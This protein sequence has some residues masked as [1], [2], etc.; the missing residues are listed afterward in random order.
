MR[1]Y[2]Q[3]HFYKRVLIIFKYRSKWKTKDLV[4]S[5]FY[6]TECSFSSI[7]I[8]AFN[9]FQKV[10]YIFLA[11]IL[12]ISCIPPGNEIPDDPR[13]FDPPEANLLEIGSSLPYFLD[14]LHA[15][16]EIN[17]TEILEDKGP[18]TV[19]MPNQEAFVKFRMEYNIR[20]TQEIP[21]DKLKSILLYH[22]IHGR[23]NFVSVPGGYHP[24]LSFEKTTG[25]PIDL[26]IETDDL[27]KINGVIVWR[28]EDLKAANGVIHS[29]PSVL[30]VPTIETHLFLNN[31]FS[32]IYEILCRS[33]LD[34]NYSQLLSEDG[35]Y[36][37]LAPT[38]EAIQSFID[39]NNEWQ[40]IYDI[41][42]STVSNLIKYHL[43]PEEN[44][45]LKNIT[46]KT[47]ITSSQGIN[48]TILAEFPKWSFSVED[49]KKTRVVKNDIQGSNGVIHQIDRALLPTD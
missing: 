11:L 7:M 26:F 3:G 43:I 25:N 31:E 10:Q 24:T 49:G 44:L 37:F 5:Y 40:T 39:E 17:V 42:A 36:T 20:S 46:Q 8:I 41:P 18:Y 30:E 32:S 13:K 34:M 23:Y 4:I 16:D 29:I 1:L 45:L 15:M 35:P 6:K 48:I 2:E 21:H 19:F 12:L 27:L 14:Y 28:D 33:D 22:F 47:E 38:N 9:I